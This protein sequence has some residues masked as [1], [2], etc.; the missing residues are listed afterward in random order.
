M[1]KGRKNSLNPDRGLLL[2]SGLLC[3]GTWG[4]AGGLPAEG[5][6]T[7]ME[8]SGLSL[9]VG[10]IA[11]CSVIWVVLSQGGSQASC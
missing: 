1:A 2:S 5:R 4:L 9:D 8:G 6:E 11:S 10:H 7:R 3:T